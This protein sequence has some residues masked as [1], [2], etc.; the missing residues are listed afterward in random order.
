[1]TRGLF[2]LQKIQDIHSISSIEWPFSKVR[3]VARNPLL[4]IGEFSDLNI[5]DVS[6]KV[7][8]AV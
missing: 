2:G 3:T 4:G 1:M 8:G 7:L 6:A 5:S